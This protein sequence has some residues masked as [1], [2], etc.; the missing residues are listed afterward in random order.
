MKPAVAVAGGVPGG[1]SAYGGGDGC[2]SIVQTAVSIVDDKGVIVQSS[3]LPG[4]VLAVDIAVSPDGNSIA[5]ASA[6][7]RDPAAPTQAFGGVMAPTEAGPGFSRGFG[8]SGAFEKGFGGSF[9]G[10][11]GR[12]VSLSM[13]SNAFHSE[14]EQVAMDGCVA[15]SE[16]DVPGQPI[17]VR[18]RR[19][20]AAGAEP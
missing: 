12:V 14:D 13:S 7:T 5:V 3:S 8:G 16:M 15:S 4:T 18:T 6:G 19:R 1:G 11:L 10:A 17:A 20:R 9:Q 2:Q